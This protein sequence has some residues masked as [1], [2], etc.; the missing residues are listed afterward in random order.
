[1]EVDGDKSEEKKVIEK[2]EEVVEQSKKERR[3][4]LYAKTSEIRLVSDEGEVGTEIISKV[5]PP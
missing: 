3:F 2:E 5:T 4:L 1:M